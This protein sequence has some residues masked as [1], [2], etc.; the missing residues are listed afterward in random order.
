VDASLLQMFTDAA[1]E[2]LRG[3]A[4]GAVRW[5]RPVLSLPIGRGQDALYLA[6]ILESPGPFCYL[7]VDDPLQ[8]VPGSARFSALAGA[9]VTDVVRPPG[10]RILKVEALPAGETGDDVVLS[11]LLFGSAGRAELARRDGTYLQHVGAR[12][13]ARE[14]GGP[15]T[16]PSPQGSFYLI[17]RGRIGRVAPL[18]A[19]D[20]EAVH[21]FGP[22][23]DAV[24]G[25]AEVGLQLLSDAHER[26]VEGRLRP[27]KRQVDTRRKLMNKL[28]AERERADGHQAIRREA[29]TLAA[30]QTSIEPGA[31]WVDLPDVYAPETTLRIGLDP[32]LPLRTQIEKRFKKAAKLE[33]SRAHN[34][35]RIEEVRREV[36]SLERD[37]AAVE[38]AAGF[39]RA[40]EEIAR[41]ER[42]HPW[43]CPPGP[44]RAADATG[45]ARAPRPDRSP[46][47]QFDLDDMWF[48]L[49]GRNNRENDELTF[50]A[51][52]PT[53]LWFHAQQMAGSHVV[54]KAR[55]N[56]GSPP[57]RILEAAASIA[58]YFS[59]AKHSDLAPVIYTQRK[60]VRKFRGAKP[61]QVTCEREKTLMVPPRLP[62]ATS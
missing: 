13:Q 18:D 52:A 31:E 56:P 30:Y 16:S 62:G 29:E 10:D 39:A 12:L 60:Y 54:L 49:V 9:T 57:A 61:G 26:I 36:E 48:V 41:L 32:S 1:R 28:N 34:R 22:Y 4:I 47:R 51:A 38:G 7:A 20:P 2:R 58:A 59:K 11:L 23:D 43:L 8:G 44:G 40:M 6:V 17:S 55:G 19:D 25:C 15:R 45:R 50:R 3:R 27:L 24:A 14:G 37:V 33:R 42:I 35:R 5:C 46:F 21:R 53:D